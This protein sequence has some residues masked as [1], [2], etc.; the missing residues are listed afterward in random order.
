[1]RPAGMPKMECRMTK[2]K[3]RMGVSLATI[4]VFIFGFAHAD[5]RPTLPQA[6]RTNGGQ[7]LGGV[8][9]TLPGARA[10]VAQIK[11]AKGKALSTAVWVAQDGY[12]LT[13]ASEV[14]EIEKQRIHWATD[15]NAAIREIRRLNAH[16]L[17]LAQ[18]VG[19]SG[20]KPAKF[21]SGT[22]QTA[23]GQ[24]LAAP[25]KG[26]N[27]IRIGVISAQPRKIQGFGAAMGIRM[28]EQPSRIPGVRITGLAEESPAAAAGLKAGD[29]ITALDGKAATDMKQ[30]SDLIKSYQ[31][32]DFME[33]KYS[34]EGKPY[35]TRVRLASRMKIMMNWDGEDFANG[36]ISLRTD[37]Y[38]LIIQ[39]DLPLT[40]LD[41]G[42][43]LFDLEGRAI[44]INIARVDRVTTFAL[45]AS[46]FWKGIEPL[47]E[48][49]RHP[50]KALRP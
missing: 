19:V 26:G 27:E 41:M 22:I 42:G 16:D 24:W 28:D 8:E 38:A 37:N 11:D 20:V 36:G 4:L 33:V 15:Q 47:I 17:I 46:V 7:I 35:T 32:G 18:A 34:R 14:P 43:P 6:E 40:P 2:V 12:F 39:H 21:S 3:L 13:K 30:V 23:Y 45:P 1:M 31:P 49:D 10:A 25:V 44:G 29:L 9:T 48:A 50:P 5:T